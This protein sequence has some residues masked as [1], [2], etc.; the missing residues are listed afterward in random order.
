MPQFIL[1]PYDTPEMFDGLSPEEIQRVIE[2]YYAWTASVAQAGRLVGGYKLRDG[3]GRLMRG[4]G[5]NLEV[6][7]G[8]YSET[9]EVIGGV[10]IVEGDSYDDV[11]GLVAD[12]PHLAFGRLAIRRI[13]E[14]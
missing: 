11:V 6:T 9:K 1:F 7:D 2:K 8:P 13:E 14:G 3:E 4:A 10:W 12:C 5:S